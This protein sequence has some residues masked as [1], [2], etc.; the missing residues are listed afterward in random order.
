[1]QEGLSMP[2]QMAQAWRQALRDRA[3]LELKRINSETQK[4]YLE[5]M[6]EKAEEDAFKDAARHTVEIISGKDWL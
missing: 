5:M 1:M 2:E 6:R 4:I 3:E